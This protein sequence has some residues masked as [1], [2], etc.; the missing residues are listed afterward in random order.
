MTSSAPKIP[1]DRVLDWEISSCVEARPTL[2]GVLHRY[3]DC[4]DGKRRLIDYS[5][6]RYKVAE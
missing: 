2:F 6:E 1:W 3:A 5:G 4:S